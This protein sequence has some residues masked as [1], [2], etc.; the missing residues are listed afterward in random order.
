MFGEKFVADLV[1]E[2]LPSAKFL[3]HLEDPPGYL[4]SGEGWELKRLVYR[5]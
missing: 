2:Y 4:E 3:R 1:G 5:V